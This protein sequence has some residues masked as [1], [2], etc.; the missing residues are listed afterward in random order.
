ML[1]NWLFMSNQVPVEFDWI[2]TQADINKCIDTCLFCTSSC[3]LGARQTY[4]N[5]CMYMGHVYNRTCTYEVIY[6]FV[7]VCMKTHIAT[8]MSDRGMYDRGG[9]V[10]GMLALDSFK[11]AFANMFR[12]HNT[13]LSL[14][15]SYAGHQGH[16]DH[17]RSR[18]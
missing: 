12:A 1:L 11:S 5:A 18:A 6:I 14:K 4:P 16:S 13:S 17:S 3:M 2:Y 10:S 7:H 8:Y 15:M 9:F